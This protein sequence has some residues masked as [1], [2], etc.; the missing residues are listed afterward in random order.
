MSYG[1]EAAPKVALPPSDARTGALSG[2]VAATLF[3]CAGGGALFVLTIVGVAAGVSAHASSEAEHA[4][5]AQ[6]AARLDE[7]QAQLE[8]DQEAGRQRFEMP[9]HERRRSESVSIPAMPGPMD[10]AYGA[11]APRDSLRSDFSR[12]PRLEPPRFEPGD[13]ER[14]F[15]PYALDVS[16]TRA[17]E[18][19]LSASLRRGEAGRSPLIVRPVSV[20]YSRSAARPSRSR[21]L[22]D[23]DDAESSFDP[24]AERLERLQILA[25]RPDAFAA[26]AVWFAQR[27]ASLSQAMLASV[28]N[29]IADFILRGD[30]PEAVRA[31]P[32]VLT[33]YGRPNLASLAKLILGAVKLDGPRSTLPRR[34]ILIGAFQRYRTLDAD[35]RDPAAGDVLQALTQSTTIS[36]HLVPSIEALHPP[37]EEPVEDFLIEYSFASS[38]ESM[39]AQR[40]ALLDPPTCERLLEA[41]IVRLE[42]PEEAERESAYVILAAAEPTPDRTSAVLDAIR[43]AFENE[44]V[45]PS[46]AACAA[47]ACWIDDEHAARFRAFCDCD[48]PIRRYAA[49]AVVARFPM[50]TEAFASND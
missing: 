29:T 16:S 50:E 3:F 33:W 41:A 42:S 30:S 18:T 38:S 5:R 40:K 35:W 45:A 11:E 8:H 9:R 20:S 21:L 25:Q 17:E 47:L 43:I 26:E 48:C 27:R 46:P 12:S 15:S 14:R 44:S 7:L 49:R 31:L 34:Q 37:Y 19:A 2:R 24:S 32:K 10:S 13:V 36:S 6:A 23:G 22:P 1:L 4:G 28:E 39:H